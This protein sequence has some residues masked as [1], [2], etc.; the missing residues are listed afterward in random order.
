MSGRR[1]DHGKRR[2]LT[3]EQRATLLKPL[4]SA[5]TVL[6]IDPLGVRVLAWLAPVRAVTPIRLTVAAQLAGVGAAVAFALDHL[7]LGALLFELRFF[8]DCLDGKL[9]RLRGQTSR[10]GAVLD[11]NADKVVVLA[12]FVALGASIDRPWLAVALAAAY[13]LQF[14][15]REQRD[16]LFAELDLRKPIER[17]S[18][19]GVA[20]R[21]RRRR[22]YPTVT[23][24]EV[25][26]GA[27]FVIPLLAVA[28]VAD[29]VAVGLAASAVY[30][31][32]QGLRFGVSALRAAAQADR[33]RP[34]SD[35]DA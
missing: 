7:L 13:P 18:L 20:G 25:E 35:A 3:A 10:F 23:T 34:H 2:S 16:A 1:A 19:H 14:A 9:A 21:L 8:V 4:D 22:I 30:F 24:I 5:W 11:S 29:L 28:G 6:L 33:V 12:S 31:A 27:L 32:L 26:H 15:F 17:V